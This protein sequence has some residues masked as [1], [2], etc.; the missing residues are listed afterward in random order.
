M[1]GQRARGWPDATLSNIYLY[2]IHTPINSKK[3]ELKAHK[4]PEEICKCFYGFIILHNID[5]EKHLFLPSELVD[6]EFFYNILTNWVTECLGV[7]L[8]SLRVN[9]D[10]KPW[11]HSRNPSFVT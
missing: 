9:C 5:S 3:D 6:R 11:E 7:V 1:D 4:S 8:T 2:L 10:L